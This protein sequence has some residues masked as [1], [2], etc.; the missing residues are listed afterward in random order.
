MCGIFAIYLE[1]KKEKNPEIVS[2]QLRALQKSWSVHRMSGVHHCPIQL[3]H[4]SGDTNLFIIS[5]TVEDYSIIQGSQVTKLFVLFALY[6]VNICTN[7]I[8]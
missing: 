4:S 7:G 3:S 8:K 1:K 2:H 5:L 6:S